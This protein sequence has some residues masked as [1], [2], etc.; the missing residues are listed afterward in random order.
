MVGPLT[1][2]WSCMAC[3]QHVFPR[4]HVILPVYKAT[5]ALLFGE[6]SEDEDEGNNHHQQQQ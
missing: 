1:I 6:P 5:R 3:A 2:L 4:L